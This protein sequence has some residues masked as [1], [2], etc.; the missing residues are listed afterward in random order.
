M[1]PCVRDPRTISNHMEDILKQLVTETVI[2]FIQKLI[3]E[4]KQRNHLVA[5]KYNHEV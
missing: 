3:L 5:V 1:G 2:Y 4:R